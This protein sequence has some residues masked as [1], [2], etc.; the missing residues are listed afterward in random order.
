MSRDI[1]FSRGDFIVVRNPN[2]GGCYWTVVNLKPPEDAPSPEIYHCHIPGDNDFSIAK[3]I[4]TRAARMVNG[5]EHSWPFHYPRRLQQGLSKVLYGDFE[6]YKKFYPKKKK[7][8][9]KE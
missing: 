1:R 4:A 3:M 8:R 5:R 6:I 2:S 9:Y 7:K